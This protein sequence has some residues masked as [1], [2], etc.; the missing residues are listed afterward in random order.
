[1]SP[2]S[3][4]I[5]EKLCVNFVDKPFQII[6]GIGIPVELQMESVTIGYV[7]KSQYFLP[8][9]ASNYLDP[10]SDPFDLTPQ[11]IT[12]YFLRKRRQLEDLQ[13]SD[14]PLLERPGPTEAATSKNSSGFDSLLNQKYEKYEVNAVEVESGTD[15]PSIDDQ[16][17]MSDGDYL[18]H[19]DET[20]C[21]NDP[22]Q[23]LGN[24]RWIVYKGI[25]THAKK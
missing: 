15:V 23:N 24:S 4:S 1:M 21:L 19:E 8:E 2:L 22:P 20:E 14:L 7:F 10:I 12:S 5:F 25:A 3:D 18:N 16:P 17:E 6:W 9:N 11:P 13:A